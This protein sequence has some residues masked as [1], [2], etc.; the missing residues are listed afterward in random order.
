MPW[1]RGGNKFAKVF[2]EA[3]EQATVCVS[4]GENIGVG[5]AGGSFT[6]PEHIVAVLTQAEDA[7]FRQVFVGADPHAG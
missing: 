3:D 2:V 6:N 1:R 4:T 5:T 7:I